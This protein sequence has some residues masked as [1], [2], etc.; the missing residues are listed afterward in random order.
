[1]PGPKV[2]AIVTQ[3]RLRRIVVE[4]MLPAG[5]RY[6]ILTPPEFV[7]L[8]ERGYVWAA[9]VDPGIYSAQVQPALDIL[10]RRGIYIP[11]VG[12]TVVARS[13]QV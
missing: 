1:M 10:A 4:T 3:H 5:M 12:A 11:V 9:L 2:L 13:Q 7:A 6:A 8:A